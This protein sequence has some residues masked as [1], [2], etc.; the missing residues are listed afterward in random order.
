MVVISFPSKFVLYIEHKDSETPLND[1]IKSA[2][3][4]VFI[5][6]SHYA[7]IHPNYQNL[8]LYSKPRI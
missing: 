8:N 3:G 2:N 6:K 5:T 4:M 7:I 1:K